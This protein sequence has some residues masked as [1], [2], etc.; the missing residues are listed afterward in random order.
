MYVMAWI[1]IIAGCVLM[2]N[3]IIHIDAISGSAIRQGVVAT[4]FTQALV[5]FG[6]G[7]ILFGIAGP[8][9]RVRRL[10]SDLAT[11]RNAHP[12]EGERP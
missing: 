9:D 3:T 2:F 4:Y 6:V 8:A 11:A 7:T 1:F 10:H 5:A 12:T